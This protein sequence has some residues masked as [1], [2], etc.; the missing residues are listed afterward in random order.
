MT[1]P[2]S[3]PLTLSAINS[4]FALGTNLNSYRGVTWYTDAGA[5]GTFTSSNL[6]FDQFYGKRKDAPYSY[7]GFFTSSRYIGSDF[8]VFVYIL[9][10][11]PGASFQI[12]GSSTT[13]GQ[14][15]GLV[16]AGNLDSNGDFGSSYLISPSDPYWFPAPQT[17]CFD[18]YQ[19]GVFIG[20]SCES[21]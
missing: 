16:A 15:L 14:P 7:G 19:D 1:L 9:G 12:Y 8:Y 10:G 3:G 5:S 6:G 11:Q 13:S 21:S 18:G 17:N 20:S 2:T 4:E